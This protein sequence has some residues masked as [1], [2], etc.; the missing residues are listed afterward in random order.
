MATAKKLPSGSWRVQVYSHSKDGKKIRESF[1]APTKAEAEMKAAKFSVNRKRRAK[2]D[3]TVGEALD[4]YIRLGG[5]ADRRHCDAQEPDRAEMDS[6]YRLVESN[7]SRD[8]ADYAD[9]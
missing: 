2:H 7:G 8:C 6:G 5:W 9:V 1:T 3:L 4:G